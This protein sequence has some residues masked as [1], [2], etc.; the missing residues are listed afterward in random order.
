MMASLFGHGRLKEGE[1]P[2]EEEK[3]LA[4]AWNHAQLPVRL[5]QIDIARKMDDNCV[6]LAQHIQGMV[7]HRKVRSMVPVECNW[8][9]PEENELMLCCG[10]ASLLNPGPAGAG[11][12]GLFGCSGNWVGRDYKLYG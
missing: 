8:L 7:K 1:H 6:R 12:V 10:G 4:T 3:W 5:G 11:C 9:R 2:T